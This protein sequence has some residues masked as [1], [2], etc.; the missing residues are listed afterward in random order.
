MET[1]N[2]LNNIIEQVK[3]AQLKLANSR[4]KSISDNIVKLSGLSPDNLLFVTFIV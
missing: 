2:L 3:E 4:P 1:T